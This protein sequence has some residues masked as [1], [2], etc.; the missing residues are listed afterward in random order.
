MSAKAATNTAA[1][2]AYTEPQNYGPDKGNAILAAWQGLYWLFGA[3]AEGFRVT[4]E[5]VYVDGLTMWSDYSPTDI[6]EDISRRNRRLDLIETYPIVQG[7]NPPP[8]ATSQD[9]TLY[10]VQ[11]WK[12][13]QG[14]NS[15]RSPQYLRKASAEFKQT[16]GLKAKRGPRRKIFRV[17]ALNEIDPTAFKDVEISE[18]D[19]FIATLKEAKA[20]IVE[21]N[22]TVENPTA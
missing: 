19:A 20:S 22:S 10:M 16:V 21:H 13:S 18:I 9:V 4:P 12:G 5:G 8:F 3:R 1:E 11:F 2:R 17:D 14:D 15:S 7:E 6:V